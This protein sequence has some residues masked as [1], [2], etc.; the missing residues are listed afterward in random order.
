MSRRDHLRTGQVAPAEYSVER[1]FNESRQEQKQTAELRR[2]GS[3]LKRQ[4]SHV[5]PIGLSGSNARRPFLV[6]ASRQ[7]GETFL[8]EHA[9]HRHRAS[10]DVLPL[11]GLT[12]I[13]D[14]QILF[15]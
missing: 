2:E 4:H 15:A 3:W 7:F 8:L 9:G 11:Q 5:G 14:G 13:I 1:H 12:D 10:L 6:R